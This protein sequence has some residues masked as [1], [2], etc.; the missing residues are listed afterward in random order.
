MKLNFI[1]PPG[2]EAHLNVS[3]CKTIAE[4]SIWT[5]RFLPDHEFKYSL[6]FPGNL[7]HKEMSESDK[8]D[9]AARVAIAHWLA[10]SVLQLDALHLVC[11]QDTRRW[12]GR[13]TG[14]A[15]RAPL[16]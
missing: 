8:C 16:P 13:L 11:D 1:V 7:W 9:D 14:V 12:T 15:E 6:E 5:G 10:S 4:I 2:A 3:V